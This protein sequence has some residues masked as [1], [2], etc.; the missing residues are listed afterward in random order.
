MKKFLCISILGL[1]GFS[2]AQAGI[3]EQY[4]VTTYNGGTS[5]HGLSPK[6]DYSQFDFKGLFTISEDISNGR[7]GSLVGTLDN[8]TET[9][10][11]NLTLGNW[12]DTGPYKQ[13]YGLPG[14]GLATGFADFFLDIDG[15]IVI[16][17]TSYD[18]IRGYSGF[19]FQYGLGANAK[20]DSELGA[21]AWITHSG[22]RL[23][24]GGTSHWDLNLAYSAVPEPSVIALFGLGLVG[25]GFARRR[26]V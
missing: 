7:T 21:S 9:G 18:D 16:D 4:N 26:K 3:I 19:V 8:G 6:G 25:L 13:E 11:V 1:F 10:T 22:Q 15:T 12:A 17:G 23:G 20:N 14:G 5:N 2:S 24:N